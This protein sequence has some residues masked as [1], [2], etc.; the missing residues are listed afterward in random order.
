MKLYSSR[1]KN[2]YCGPLEPI[3]TFQNCGDYIFKIYFKI[4][5]I[6]KI[7]FNIF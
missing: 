1:K 4:K 7:Y 5:Y 6:F 2:R 3:G